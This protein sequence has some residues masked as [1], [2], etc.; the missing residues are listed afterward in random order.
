MEKSQW[1]LKK[2]R[3]QQRRFAR[4]DDFVAMHKVIE[5]LMHHKVCE[6]NLEKNIYVMSHYIAGVILHGKREEVWRQTLRQVNFDT[7]SAVVSFVNT[8]NVHWKLLM[9]EALLEA[10]PEK[11][12]MTFR[13]TETCM[14]AQRTRMALTIIKASGAQHSTVGS[15]IVWD[16]VTRLGRGVFA[17]AFRNGDFVLEYRGKLFPPDSPPFYT[18]TEATYLFEFKW[19]GR[20]WCLDASLEDQSL[21]RLVNDEH[22]N[23][24]CKMRVLQVDN[25][26]HLCLF[27]VRDIVPGEKVTYSYGDSDWPWHKQPT[28]QS[29]RS[30]EEQSREGPWRKKG[31]K[32]GQGAEQGFPDRGKQ[33][34]APIAQS[35]EQG[36]SPAQDTDCVLS[37][38]AFARS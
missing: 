10:Y 22:R 24:N 13:T 7:Y 25:M 19:K 38:R 11:P 21:G 20:S 3:L 8:G 28:A 9:A 37:R 2:V 12:K 17:S 18:E 14:V 30:I 34:S 15:P 32:L 35:K 29:H 26:P 31:T 33:D 27:V 1:D 6:M 4:M 23:P 5:S 36:G 16:G